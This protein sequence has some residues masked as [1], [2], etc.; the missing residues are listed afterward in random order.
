MLQ[1]RLGLSCFFGRGAVSPSA[2][3]MFTLLA[4]SAAV[5]D[6]RVCQSGCRHR[7]VFMVMRSAFAFPS[8]LFF[9]SSAL[10]KRTHYG[11][12][13]NWLKYLHFPRDPDYSAVPSRLQM[14]Y[15]GSS[16]LGTHI[17]G[18][19]RA[20][21]HFF[22]VLDSRRPMLPHL[23]RSTA[24]SYKPYYTQK[25]RTCVANDQTNNPFRWLIPIC[26]YFKI[27]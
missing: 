22:A 27:S 9:S 20:L 6:A 24:A 11:A 15:Y 21:N 25:V 3:L 18:R 2:H 12:E 4:P 19:G 17:H 10:L 26:N 8:G 14:T 5:S 23:L 16:A 7:R 1:Y 13:N